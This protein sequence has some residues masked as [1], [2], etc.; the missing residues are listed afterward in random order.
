MPVIIDIG[1]CC[2]QEIEGYSEQGM[3]GEQAQGSKSTFGIE[4]EKKKNK[5]VS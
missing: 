2:E 3:D 5:E 1:Y 4:Q